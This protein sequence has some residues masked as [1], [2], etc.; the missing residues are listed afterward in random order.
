MRVI[1]A[2]PAICTQH[3]IAKLLLLVSGYN[4]VCNEMR[5]EPGE[6]KLQEFEFEV[7]NLQ[8]GGRLQFLAHRGIKLISEFRIIK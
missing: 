3:M 4:N 7:M 2:K 1:V 5:T 8:V 6:Q